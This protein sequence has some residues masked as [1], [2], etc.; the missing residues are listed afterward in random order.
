MVILKYFFS[1]LI[2]VC[3]D[4]MHNIYYLKKP[5]RQDLDKNSEYFTLPSKTTL[6]YILIKTWLAL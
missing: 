2:S 5:E 3:T 4:Q 6:F 1:C